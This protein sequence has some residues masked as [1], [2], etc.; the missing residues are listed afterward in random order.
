MSYSR[1]N[2]SWGNSATAILHANDAPWQCRSPF[3]IRFLGLSPLYYVCSTAAQVKQSKFINS[4]SKFLQIHQQLQAAIQI[5]VKLHVTRLDCTFTTLIIYTRAVGVTPSTPSSMECTSRYLL[6]STVLGLFSDR[7][8][9]PCGLVMANHIAL[10]LKMP[11]AEPPPTLSHARA[12]CS[13]LHGT[14]YS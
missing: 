2:V 10:C 13:W 4:C 5:H 14:S 1:A 8:C 7:E 11:S 12:G 3:K 9:Q 6:T